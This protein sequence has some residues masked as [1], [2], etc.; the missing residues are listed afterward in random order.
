M[1]KYKLTL[2]QETQPVNRN[3]KLNHKLKKQK[4]F[5]MQNLLTQNYN[6]NINMK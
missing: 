5:K 6:N 1:K 3:N 2:S 4:K